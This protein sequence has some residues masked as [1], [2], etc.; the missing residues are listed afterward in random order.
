M[1]PASRA[2]AT[3]A[4]FAAVPAL[5]LGLIL[6]FT[7][8]WIA[9]LVAFLV[10]GAGLGSWAR[11]AGDRLVI[12]RLA[13]READPRSEARLCNLVE[14]LSTGAGVR[15]PKLLIVDSPG[16]NAMAFGT[17]ASRSAVAVTS[18]L[19]AELDRIEL[20]AVLAEALYQVRHEETVPA[21][22]LVATFGI[23]RPVALR[24]DQ[25]ATADQGAVTLT[26]YPPA[27]ASALEK[28]ERKGAAVDGQ[29]SWM[30]HLWLADPRRSA[31]PQRGRLLL[32]DRVE[33]LREL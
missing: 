13:A 18:G 32:H 30:A 5:V 33:A 1:S 31:I 23:G 21:T 20:E 22:V 4:L 29:P 14:G 7:V 15:Y 24:A 9:G 12:A 19:L 10:V 17:T 27:L 16:L 6:L 2:L 28:I 25:D 3:A 8:G 11:L 26:R